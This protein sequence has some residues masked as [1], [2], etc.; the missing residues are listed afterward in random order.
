MFNSHC[1]N[2]NENKNIEKAAAGMRI[3]VIRIERPP[4]YPLHYGDHS[5]LSVKYFLYVTSKISAVSINSILQRTT[6]YFVVMNKLIR[7]QN[8]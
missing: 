6:H 1:N 3:H 2:N 5:K 8:S 7:A 4:W